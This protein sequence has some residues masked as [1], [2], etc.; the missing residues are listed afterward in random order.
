MSTPALDA[1]VPRGHW[2]DWARRAL[3]LGIAALTVWLVWHVAQETDWPAVGEALRRRGAAELGLIALL[4]L[5]S[6]AL[7]GFIDLIGVSALSLNVGRARSW[8]IATASYACNLNLGSLVGAAALRLKL[9]AREG[10][11][12]ADIARLIALS[13]A[14]N[15]MGY[16]L[17]LATLPLWSSLGVLSRWTGHPLALA[18]CAGA[19]C[20][21]ALYL[22]A[23]ATQRSLSLRGHSFAFPPWRPAL[24]Q[25]A[26]GATNWALMG[27]VLMLS[28]GEGVDYADALGALLIGAVA[29]VITHVPGGWGVL[30]FV[31]LKSLA[32]SLDGHKVVAGVL[33][34]R[35]AYYLLP[36]A[37]A[38]LNLGLL[39]L[40]RKQH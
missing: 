26:A 13:M 29:G 17:L 33:V 34:Y 1:A 11:G 4:A 31:I 32:G 9:Y 21:V 30:D 24:A 37:V 23:C 5:A 7:Y 12:T 6:H 3:W 25:I 10:L 19:I 38:V 15:W 28:L 39:T 16:L 8:R 2:R 40:K 20:I 18:L 22:Y 27:L 35:A 36:L 14:A